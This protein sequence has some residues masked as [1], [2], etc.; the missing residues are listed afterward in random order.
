M[1][2]STQRHFAKYGAGK[3]YLICLHTGMLP[4]HILFRHCAQNDT[5][6]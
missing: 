3:I 4:G 5:L 1:D 6:I 2:I